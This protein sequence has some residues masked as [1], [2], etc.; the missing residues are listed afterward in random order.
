[1]RRIRQ[2]DID[3]YRRHGATVLRG[4]IAPTW[5]RRLSAAVQQNM[6]APGPMANDYTDAGRSGRYFGDYC[7]WNRI[8]GY[9]D[10]AFRSNLAGMAARLMGSERV[11]LFHE[12][13]LVK[14][15]GT[16]EAT[17][18]HHDQPYYVIGGSQVIS[19]WVPLD[20]VPR[21]I[22]PRFL[23][24]SHRWG[25][26]FYPRRF[27]DG[28]DYDYEGPGFETVPDID[29]GTQEY[30]ITAWDLA[31][32][33]AVAFHFLTLH[34]APVNASAGRRR[35]IAWRFFGD[36][37]RWAT[38]PGRP[39]PPYPEMGLTLNDGDALPE[40]W[41]PVVWP[42]PAADRLERSAARS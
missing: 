10:F 8:A 19:F 42:R 22:C 5:L 3:D 31:P 4:V 35:A 38:R 26:L 20:P 23:R 37:A 1:M 16:G 12:H 28:G 24:G 11:Q 17:P 41:F 25:K 27:L 2:S 18:W 14:E 33:D 39:S 13:V 9:R 32:G 30:D 29:G 36:D 15:P 6:D 21:Q 34:D 7:N 40:A